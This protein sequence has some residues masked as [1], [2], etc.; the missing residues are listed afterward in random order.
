ML[1]S[2]IVVATAIMGATAAQAGEWAT[3]SE[4]ETST[5]LYAEGGSI[6]FRCN[7]EKLVAMVAFSGAVADQ[8]EVETGRMKSVGATLSVDGEAKEA[9]MIYLPRADLIFATK[10]DARKLFNA[11]IRGDA[12]AVDAGRRGSISFTPPAAEAAAFNAFKTA[13]G[14]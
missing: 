10:S 8:A 1:K 12:I 6:A 4:G 2:V 7:G 14:I 5:L 3:K 9:R 11:A 13:C